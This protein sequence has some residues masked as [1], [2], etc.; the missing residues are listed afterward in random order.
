MSGRPR[1]IKL[2]G[3]LLDWPELPANFARW[4]AQQRPA[5]QMVVAGGGR[6]VESLRELDRAGG[7][8]PEMSHWLAV[9]A[10][11]LT[12]A[13][14]AELLDGATL[15]TSLDALDTADA[16]R[17]HVFDV[18]RFLRE[19]AGAS[20]ALPCGWEVTS[21][22]IAAQVARRID[23]DELVLLKSA[24]PA[25]PFDRKALAQSGFVDAYFPRAS[26]GLAVRI[27]NLR[28]VGFPQCVTR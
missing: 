25:G 27:V 18:E 26:C 21:D 14:A 9:R 4:L 1:V 3:S 16:G 5:A 19:D 24:L 11:G 15:T 23:A 8:P 22:S 13:L 12:A 17:L 6:L 28:D 10:M 2:G 7:F 20:D